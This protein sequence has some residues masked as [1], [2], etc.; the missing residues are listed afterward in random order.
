[1]VD[2]FNQQEKSLSMYKKLKRLT[3]DQ[4]QELILSKKKTIADN[5]ND[6]IS[7]GNIDKMNDQISTGNIDVNKLT[8]SPHAD[9]LDNPEG[10]R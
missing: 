7:T 3:K 10:F 6:Q 2:F 5:M 4:Q 1:M 9:H 8:Q